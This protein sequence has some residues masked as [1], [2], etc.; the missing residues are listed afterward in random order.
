MCQA[1]GTGLG[2]FVTLNHLFEHTQINVSWIYQGRN[3]EIYSNMQ[4]EVATLTKN[5]AFCKAIAGMR[6]FQSIQKYHTNTD[7]QR[8]HYKN[9]YEN[10][11]NKRKC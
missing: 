3:P 11:V 8:T 6:I 10:S 5:T 4:E 1:T 7:T 2:K 9:I